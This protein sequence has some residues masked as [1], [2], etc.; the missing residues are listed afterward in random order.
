ARRLPNGDHCGVRKPREHEIFSEREAFRRSGEWNGWAVAPDDIATPGIQA[1]KLG[2]CRNE[3]QALRDDRSRPERTVKR[4]RP[5][6]R[7]FADVQWI[8]LIGCRIAA[9][10]ETP[11]RQRPVPITL[12]IRWLG[13]LYSNDDRNRDER[14][15]QRKP[16]HSTK[17][18]QTLRCS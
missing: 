16:P 18:H 9:I 1:E 6:A 3:H 14:Q 7:Q 2:S 12:A 8:D 15:R 4:C 13:T 11:A 17:R 5:R 10:R